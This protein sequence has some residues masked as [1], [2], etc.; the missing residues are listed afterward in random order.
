M[1]RTFAP[2]VAA[3]V[4]LVILFAIVTWLPLRSART[5]WRG[6]HI[7]D[8]IATAEGWSRT[9][10]WPRQ[11]EQVLA[12]AYLT[13]GHSDAAKPYLDALR[14]HEL[15]FS[16]MAKTDVANRLFAR[17]D[18]AGFLLYDAAI[19]ERKEPADATLYRAAAL[20]ET[21]RIPAANAVLR[22]IDRR[23]VDSRK[24]SA[25]QNALAQE[26]PHVLDRDGT[27]IGANPDYQS[28]IDAHAGK[29]TIGAY[30]ARI[31]HHE[32]IETTL[33]SAVQHAAKEALKGYRGSIVAIDPRTNELL[34]IA[35]SDPNG[36]QSNLALEA[37]YEPGSIIK[38]LTGLNAM[39]SGV[40]VQS[41]FPY[42]CSGDL[43]ID[44]RHFGDW[45]P[46]GHGDLPDLDEALAES[47][48]VYFADL[49]LKLGAD[50][51]RRFMIS[52]GFDGQTDIGLFQVPLGQLKGEMFN[53]FETASLAIGLEHESVTALHVAMLAS[54]M[55]NRG[56]LTTP[57]LVRARRSLLGEVVTGPGPQAQA[58]IA[59]REAAERMVQAMIAVVERPKGTGRRADVDAL[60]LA[61]KT[62]T[63]GK[64]EDGYQ[65]VIMA[66]AP[67]DAPRIAFGI[68]AE[69][70]GP[71]EYAGAKI[72]HD[73]VSAI[74]GRIIK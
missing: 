33:D 37:Q 21:D 60:S 41:M 74:Q 63:A 67:A 72:A 73:F 30:A 38:V 1:R 71:A 52:A 9:R 5:Q 58:R 8:A 65:A 56:V 70:A 10:M 25:L 13:S 42:H 29:L 35:S 3:L 40:D 61:L 28:F 4:V 15:W 57:R 54:M 23:A 68:I 32:T 69:N 20:A 46:F 19:H 64:R 59:P 55:A 36:H 17:G 7:A 18:Y 43:L 49:G 24:L 51:L 26:S 11:Y 16:V 48:N 53:Q 12:A 45:L 6:G 31:G 44:G 22:S 66:F 2:L 47:C 62:G 50:R 39:S 34:A 27:T 14:G